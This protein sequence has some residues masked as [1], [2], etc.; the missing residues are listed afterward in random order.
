MPKINELE[1]EIRDILDKTG[2][3]DIHLAEGLIIVPVMEAIEEYIQERD[4]LSLCPHCNCMTNKICGKCKE[5]PY[6]RD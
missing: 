6:D 1:S 5:M 4:M 2:L 3:V